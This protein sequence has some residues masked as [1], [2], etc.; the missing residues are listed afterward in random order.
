MNVFRYLINLEEMYGH[1]WQIWSDEFTERP[2][3]RWMRWFKTSWN[4]KSFSQS[5]T[6]GFS[7]DTSVTKMCCCWNIKIYICIFVPDECV[8]V[9]CRHTK[10]S[11]SEMMGQ[12]TIWTVNWT[13]SFVPW[14]DYLQFLFLI[15]WLD[16]WFDWGQFPWSSFPVSDG[17]LNLTIL[18]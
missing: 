7:W 15:F 1:I 14:R 16:Y 4:C 17:H 12:N 9:L 11:E 10:K 2:K 8:V 13:T 5:M 6:M 3:R 18:E